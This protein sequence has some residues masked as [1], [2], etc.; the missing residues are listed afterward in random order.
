MSK[1]KIQ[2]FDKLYWFLRH[3]VD[4]S[5]KASY[6]SII[7]EGKENIPTDGAIIYAPNHTNTIMDALVV[8]AMDSKPKVFVARADIFRNKT[9]A[10]ILTFLKI[11]PIMRQRDGFNELKKNHE[12]IEK[13]VDVLKDKIPFCIFPEGT[14]QTKYSS[15]PL[16][17]GIFRIAFQAQEIMPQMP[18]YII[19]TGLIYGNFFRFRSTVRVQI[20]APINV[21]KFI[22]EHSDLSQQEQMNKMKDLLTQRIHSTILYIPNDENYD[23]TYEICNIMQG[24]EIKELLKEKTNKR[25]HTLNLQLKAN[26]KT[27]KHINELKDNNP[28]K[29]KTLFELGDK[30]NKL[31][32]SKHI[33]IESVSV[34]YPI[35]SRLPKILLMI[36]SLPYSLSISILTLPIILV[37]RCIFFLLKDPAFKNSIRFLIHLVFWPLLMIIYSIICYNIMP[38]QFALPLTLIMLPAPIIAHELWKMF[39]FIVSDLKLIRAKKLRDLHEQIKEIVKG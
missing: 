9:L 36:I 38:W 30:A 18:L 39:R 26:N 3:Y 27:L 7:Y 17:K 33:S 37:C 19:P 4:F 11:M 31:R 10:K 14:H 1:K 16:A 20:G 22:A 32:E 23:A 34:R 24:F 28:E 12:T 15:L 2:D 13:S 21:G 5:V 29:A 25:K 6:R 35:L 8:L